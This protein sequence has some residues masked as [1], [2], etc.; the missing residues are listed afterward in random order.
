M[1]E[2]LSEANVFPVEAVQATVPA[3]MPARSELARKSLEGPDHYPAPPKR[4]K[5][6]KEELLKVFGLEVFASNIVVVLELCAGSAKFSLHMQAYG[7]FVL[8]VDHDRNSHRPR[9][10]TVKLDLAEEE[11]YEILRDLLHSGVVAVLLAAVP[12]GTA[13]RAREV[14][15]SAK[16]HGPKPLRSAE[17]PRELQGLTPVD[18]MRVSKAN[19][20]YDNVAALIDV[21]LRFHA[22]VI[23]ENPRNSW[24]WSIREYDELLRKGF[25]VDFQ[26]C[27]WTLEGPARAKWTRLRT[28]CDALKQLEGQCALKH[29]HLG[30]ET[31]EGN[32]FATAQKAEYP[33]G[34][35]AAIAKVLTEALAAKGLGPFVLPE[36]LDLTASVPHRRR[37]AVLGKQPRGKQL[38]AVLSEFKCVSEDSTQEAS[39][40]QYKV[41][42]PVLQGGDIV[43]GRVVA[44]LFRTPVEF[45]EAAKS[46]QHPANLAGA[47]PDILVEF[48][49]YAEC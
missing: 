31:T 42:R 18:A 16:H 9:V 3:P 34:M 12:C 7:C 25:I 48:G 35:C 45:V 5:L 11:A 39:A 8:P 24:L 33:D 26:H 6:S 1:A 47:I 28:N 30:W 40:N 22:M 2:R 15:M 36:N 17:F 21:A 46:V 41:L 44:G 49:S 20:I 27:R 29:E 38:P 37:R 32:K 13:S 4:Q 19:A 10:P 23:V 43:E 14:R